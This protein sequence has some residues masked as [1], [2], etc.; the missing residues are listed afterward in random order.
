MTFLLILLVIYVIGKYIIPR[1]L[2]WLLRRWVMKQFNAAS[3][4]GQQGQPHQ[5]QRQRR[6][7]HTP[8]QKKKI[9]PTV[10]DY[11]EFTETTV[12][13]TQSATAPVEP[14]QQ[15]SDIDWTDL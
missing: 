15:V 6:Q 3:A 2:P 4:F 13:R 5:Q 10:G 12:E 8:S 7:S 14:E 9:D 1:V 11:V